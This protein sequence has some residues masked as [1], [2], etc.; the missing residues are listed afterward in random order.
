MAKGV[1]RANY[2]FG[3]YGCYMP[4]FSFPVEFKR[5]KDFVAFVKGEL[6]FYDIPA[7]AIKQIPF[8]RVWGHVAAHGG[9]S[10]HCSIDYK[11][12]TLAFIGLTDEEFKQ[13]V[14]ADC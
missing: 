12:N 10:V 3:L 14:E 7:S 6:A 2:S 9:S 13:A 1:Y 8:K 4:D 11:G 5:R